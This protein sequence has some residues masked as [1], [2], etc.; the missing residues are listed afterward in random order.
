MG[1][2]HRG[3]EA[4]WP[5]EKQI[6]A[7]AAYIMH[8]ITAQQRFIISVCWRLSEEGV[9]V[10]GSGDVSLPGLQTAD[11]SLSLPVADRDS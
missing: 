5:Q 8:A 10:A 7:G 4:F 6:A 1:V 11:F 9:S 3:T 2:S